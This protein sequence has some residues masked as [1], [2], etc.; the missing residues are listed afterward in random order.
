MD[1]VYEQGWSD[2]ENTSLL[3]AAEEAGYDLLVTTDQNLKYQ[4]NLRGRKLA[5]LVLLSTSWPRLQVRA[6]EI[7]QTIETMKPGEYKEFALE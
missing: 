1:T 4:Q 7:R 2:L 3:Q 6:Q 5:I